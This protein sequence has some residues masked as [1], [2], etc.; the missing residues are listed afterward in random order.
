MAVSK[1]LYKINLGKW[2]EDVALHFLIGQG[3][4]LLSRNFHTPDGELDLVMVNQGALVI[5]EVKTRRNKKF[6]LPEEAV[7]D[8]K[9][10]HLVSATEWFLQEN[11]QYA[12]NWRLDVVSVIGS[13]SGGEPQIEWFEN[14]S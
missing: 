6:G 9:V 13:P 8:E 10:D 11:P 12:E 7:T 4:S 3:F 14:V 1:N 2:G 5:V